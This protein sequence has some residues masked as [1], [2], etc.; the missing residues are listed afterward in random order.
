[1]SKLRRKFIT[2]LAVLFCALLCISAALIIPKSK[3]AYAI[4]QT[5]SNY[6]TLVSGGADLYVGDTNPTYPIDR[7]VL[8]DLYV[9]LTGDTNYVALKER[10]ASKSTKTITSA[11]FRNQQ[12]GIKNVSVYFGGVR[13]DATYL[14]FD[15]DGDVILDLW[16]SGEDPYSMWSTYNIGYAATCSADTSGSPTNMYSTSYIR[17]NEL[18]AGGYVLNASRSLVSI[19]QNSSS[20]Y[21]KFTMDDA[22]NSLTQFIVKPADVAYQET[23]SLSAVQSGQWDRAN[24]AYGTPSTGNWAS[25]AMAAYKNK[26]YYADWKNDY[27][28]LPSVT[29]T[30]GNNTNWSF[31]GLWQTDANL[32]GT[33]NP[34]TNLNVRPNIYCPVWLRSTGGDG[35]D[36]NM[37]L[38]PEGTMMSDLC[39]AKYAIRPAMHFNLTEAAMA[40][41]GIYFGTDDTEISQDRKTATLKHEYDDVEVEIDVPDNDKFAA[42]VVESESGHYSQGKLKAKLPNTDSDKDYTIKVK[43]ATDYYWL[44]VDTADWTAEKTY[45]ITIEAATISASWTGISRT[46]GENVFQNQQQY[47][48]TSSKI[49]NATFT[50]K[51]KVITNSSQYLPD[52]SSTWT[53]S[54]WTTRTSNSE[55][56]PDFIISSSVTHRV[57]YEITA[58]FHKP[59]RGYY[60][61][62]ANA[63]TATFTAKSG[64]SFSTVEYASTNA[65]NLVTQNLKTQFITNV[66]MTVQ[67]STVTLND[68]KNYVDVKLYKLVNGVRQ[69]VNIPNNGRLPAGDYYMYLVWS[70]GIDDAVKTVWLE[71]PDNVYP[72]FTVKPKDITVS[73]VGKDGKALTHV[74][75][76]DPVDLE[77]S[78]SGLAQGDS[79]GDLN[80]GNIVID[81]TSDSIEYNT[82]ANTYTLK[83]EQY[84]VGNYKVTFNPCTYEV[85]KRH[86]KLKL[87]DEQMEYGKD[88]SSFTFKAP[89]VIDGNIIDGDTL[90]GAVKSKNYYLELHGTDVDET[91]LQIS[92][93]EL[94]AVFESDNYDFTIEGATFKVTK[95]NYDMSGVTFVSKGYVYDGNPHPAAIS[96]TLPDGVTVTYRYVNTADGSETTDAP[97][98]IG[99]YLAYASFKHNDSNYNAIAD[100]VAY[101]RI[102]ATSE[103]ANQPFP[104]LPTDEEIAAAKSLA[105][106][107]EEAKKKLDEEAKAKKE[108]IDN[109]ADMTAEDKK[110]AKEEIEKELAEGN[111]AIDNAKDKD[112][113]DKAYDDGKKEMEDTVELAETKTDAKKDLEKEAKDKKD[114]IDADVNLTPEEK[115][116]AKEEID[117][118]LE[119]GKKEIDKSTKVDDVEAAGSSSEKKIED[120]TEVVQK[121]GSAKS[122]LDKAAQAKKESIDNNPDLT[123][124]EKAAAK[125]EVDK[126]LAK[127]KAEIDGATDV[128]GI[129]SVESS[130]KANIENIKPEHKGSF[131]WWI[132]AV[133]AGAI[134]LLTVIIIV[135]VKRRNADDDDG[136]YDDYYDDEYDYDEEEDEGDDEAYGY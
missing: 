27:L 124:E 122:E 98:E 121:K 69:N 40:S 71:N 2:V 134:V 109:N 13:W 73:I 26:D 64:D 82:P 18:N 93:Y 83:C 107:K 76:E 20:R 70:D 68:I 125:A 31:V 115:K 135:V 113:V 116:A 17:T 25:T 28:W 43:P 19:A 97:V 95:A 30:G 39:D 50:E 105:E 32:R 58:Q 133:I 54:G 80:L 81:G 45:K 79:E 23:E 11:D 41:G 65:I 84:E 36:Y 99:M 49:S 57:Y 123:D 130:T 127:G 119:E 67:G 96:G 24:D 87:E 88:F 48:I 78:Y 21:A 53:T 9:A 61:I 103:E 7:N 72:K 33:T 22:P 131:P 120:Y 47:P 132:L 44:D 102:A 106:K 118:Q 75:G 86:V 85:T 117:R 35:G 90:D 126:E 74:Y 89:S 129:Q 128:G 108:A 5:G 100:K 101:I 29:E 15:R 91:N 92:D 34:A 60:D 1:M 62:T 38:L 42:P 12:G 59:L 10:L 4:R 136:G 14:T 37:G 111:A 3:S 114:K 6:W 77:F 110:A 104:P 55:S 94:L 8:H 46:N 52:D 51:Y 16:Q 63:A 112:S 56:N 66:N